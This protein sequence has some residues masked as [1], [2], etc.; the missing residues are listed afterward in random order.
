MAVGAAWMVGMRITETVLGL[1][2][3]AILARLLNPDDFGIVALAGSAY[4]FFTV[5]GQFGFDWALIQ[6]KDPEPAHYDSAW[7]ANILVGLSIAIIML[8]I[9]KSVAMFFEDPRIEHVVYAFAFLS[10]AKGFEN[11]GVVNFRKSLDFRGDYFY[12]VLPKVVSVVVGVTAAYFVRNYWA[13]VMGMVASQITFLL[14]SQFSQPYRP[15]L[16]LS[17]FSDLFNF[18]RW[19]VANNILHFLTDKG[20]DVV[21]GRLSAVGDVGILR[22]A[23]KLAYLPSTEIMAPINRALFPGFSTIA[24]DVDR[25]KRMVTKVMGMTV[26][27]SVPSALGLL[28]VAEPLVRVVFGDKWLDA[29]PVISILGFVGLLSA[30]GG[31]FEP[32]L[33]ARGKPQIIV[34]Q[35]LM[36]VILL[37]PTAIYFVS[38]YGV[39]GVAIA[40][41]A[42]SVVTRPFVM[43]MSAREIGFGFGRFLSVIWRPL[44]ASLVMAYAIHIAKQSPL[45]SVIGPLGELGLLVGIGGLVYSLGLLTLWLI[46][47]RPDGAERLLLSK[48]RRNGGATSSDKKEDIA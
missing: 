35:K 13:L 1:A 9:A 11:I 5:I 2:S 15:K 46:A 48:V 4:A 36:Y 19:M 17:R 22:M 37:I 31:L 21:L 44:S 8:V 29:A 7:T 27:L 25:L 41:A 38:S 42:G 20:P 3:I 26:L 45:L 28:A 18:S 10:L 23:M 12:F 33:L 34:Y 30:L 24:G 40:L 16:D 14:Y 39:V 32:V 6:R 47:G 43:Y